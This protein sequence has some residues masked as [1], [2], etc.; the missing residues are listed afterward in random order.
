VPYAAS[1]H[2]FANTRYLVPC[3]GIAFAAGIA[4]LE[5]R[6][7]ETWLAALAVALLAQDLLQMH[8]E[9]PH[10]VRV[11]MGVLDVLALGI[12]LSPGLRA[13]TIRRARPLALAALVAGVLLAPVLG[14]FRLDD[15]ARALAQ[16]YQAHVT[17]SRLF[18]AGWGWL[19]HHGEN[20]TVDVF[21]SPATYFTYP[22][23]GQ[24]LERKATY[25]NVNVEDVREAAT[26][27]LCQ[28]RV[29]ADPDAWLVNLKKAGVRWVLA[30]RYPD[31]PY[32]IEHDWAVAHPELFKLRFQDNTN[33]VWEFLPG[34]GG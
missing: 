9:M 6:I 26:Y 31:F 27:P 30:S 7:R 14:R 20:G 13:F 12:A 34:A 11:A 17:T 16:E 4:M 24:Y 2:V 19:D 5:D 1:H 18:A 29:H 33:E 8:S 23:M 21:T 28:P 15:R 32:S 25:V 22:A 10:G 3:F